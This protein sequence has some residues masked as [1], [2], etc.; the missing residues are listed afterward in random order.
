MLVISN[1]YRHN[2]LNCYANTVMGLDNQ[3]D[4]PARKAKKKKNSLV[5]PILI[6]DHKRHNQAFGLAHWG[7][8]RLAG[9][10]VLPVFHFLQYARKYHVQ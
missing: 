9:D 1:N 3:G 8:G 2:N 4:A 5:T 6:A 7:Q 10:R